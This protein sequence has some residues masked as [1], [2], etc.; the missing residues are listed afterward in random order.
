MQ[1]SMDTAEDP[2]VEDSREVDIAFVVDLF[3][4][5]ARKDHV[6]MYE[7]LAE[8]FGEELIDS[9]VEEKLGAQA[10]QIIETMYNN[11]EQLAEQLGS[12]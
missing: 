10:A 11:Q 2:P 3:N 1:D 5:D 7:D 6:G 4:S 12:R 9:M 8:M